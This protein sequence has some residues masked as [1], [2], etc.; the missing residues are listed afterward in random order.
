MRHH[1][2]DRCLLGLLD[3]EIGGD[4]VKESTLILEL[5]PEEKKNEKK[6]FSIVLMILLW[7]QD[8]LGIIILTRS[9]KSALPVLSSGRDKCA[10]V[11]TWRVRRQR[12]TLTSRTENRKIY[13]CTWTTIVVWADKSLLPCENGAGMRG[14]R[15]KAS[16]HN[17][18]SKWSSER[19]KMIVLIDGRERKRIL[20]LPPTCSC[21]NSR[22]K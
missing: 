15:A 20:I 7:N 1:N 5:Q 14:E 22:P 3:C 13:D 17:L 6:R 11:H 10:G 18:K 19:E 9:F 8:A 21:S 12:T 16:S 2:I 4:R